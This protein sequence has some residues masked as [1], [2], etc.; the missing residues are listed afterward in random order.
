MSAILSTG[1]LTSSNIKVQDLEI[2]KAEEVGSRAIL[3]WKRQVSTNQ[4]PASYRFAYQSRP[5]R[6]W[7]GCSPEHGEERRR[8]FQGVAQSTGT[9]PQLTDTFVTWYLGKEDR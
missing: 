1:L 8:L 2:S 4:D 9:A 5:R 6:A 3:A 7:Q